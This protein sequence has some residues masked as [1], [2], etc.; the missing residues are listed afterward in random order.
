MGGLCAAWVQAV[1]WLSLAWQWVI[2]LVSSHLF[3]SGLVALAGAYFGAKT[4]QGTAARNKLRDELTKEIRDTNAAISLAFAISNSV[5]AL[6]RQHLG[7]LKEGFDKDKKDL[8]EFE[9]K[10]KTGEI[11]GNKEYV[12]RCDF[13]YLAVP[14]PPTDTLQAHVVDRLSVVGRPLNLAVAIAESAVALRESIANRNE[15]IKA[16]RSEGVKRDRAFMARFFGL[17]TG[18][19]EVDEIYS[20]TLDAMVLHADCLI[21]FTYL[22]C[23]DLQV[24]GARLVDRYRKR[25]KQ[26]PRVTQVDFAPAKA[27]NLIPPESEFESW[28]TAFV[29]LPEP[30]TRWERV[31]VALRIKRA[32]TSRQQKST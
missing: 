22:L 16:F 32:E 7:S 26:A 1:A 6:K 27:N 18:D 31:L 23:D 11:Q 25:S 2:Q 17:P 12:V 10:R 24:H 29:K 9:R 30:L 4:A 14:N 5:M 21:Y 8:I 20:T 13:R 28:S 15:Q 3:E 19:G